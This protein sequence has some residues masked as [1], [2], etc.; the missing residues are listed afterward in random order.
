MSVTEQSLAPHE[1][2]KP[3]RYI[4]F[5]NPITLLWAILLLTGAIFSILTVSAFHH[6]S[7]HEAPAPAAPA[8]EALTWTFHAKTNADCEA[9]PRC[10]L[11]CSGPHCEVLEPPAVTTHQG[12]L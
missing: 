3:Y 6:Y 8:P 7:Y 10:S 2:P 1:D 5:T 4:E 11:D 12:K 9:D